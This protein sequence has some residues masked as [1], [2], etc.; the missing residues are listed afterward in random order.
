MNADKRTGEGWY[1]P[2]VYPTEGDRYEFV[3]TF[4]HFETFRSKPNLGGVTLE[5]QDPHDQRAVL[6]IALFFAD[7]ET[8]STNMP[9]RFRDA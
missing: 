8:F 3:A 9:V 1:P 6:Y 2:G 5:H 7:H 4:D